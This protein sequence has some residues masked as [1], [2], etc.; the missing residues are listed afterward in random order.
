MRSHAQL[1]LD[2]VKRITFLADAAEIVLTHHERCDGSGYPRGLKTT[3]IPA[4]A[5]IFAIADTVDAMTSDLPYRSGGSFEMAHDEIRR[6]S[7]SRYDSRVA[8]PFLGI[9]IESWKET[10]RST[11]ILVLG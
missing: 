2:L 11:D 6:G 4:G 7:G 10:R 1:G 5:T 8:N 9:A 3:D